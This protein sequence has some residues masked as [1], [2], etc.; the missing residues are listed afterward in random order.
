[1]TEPQP[2]SEL[3]VYRTRARLT[4]RQLAE[5]SPWTQSYVAHL[6]RGSRAATEDV[7]EIM[8][9]LLGVTSAELRPGA[10]VAPRPGSPA[11]ALSNP[12]GFAPIGTGDKRSAVA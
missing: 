4:Q 2:W 9:G 6:E 8:A 5:A 3:V 12:S 7:I 11:E 1:M 10:G